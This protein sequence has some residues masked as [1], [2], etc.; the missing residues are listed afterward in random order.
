MPSQKDTYKQ[1]CKKAKDGD[2]PFASFYKTVGGGEGDRCLYPTRFDMY[3][4]GCGNDCVYCYARSL[5]GFRGLWNPEEPAMANRFQ[6]MQMIDSLPRNTVLRLGGMTDP[7]QKIEEREHRTEWLIGKLNERRIPYLIVTKCPIVK[8]CKYLDKELAHIQISVTYTDGMQPDGFEKAP[9][10]SERLK[11]CEELQERGFDV[12][13]RLSPYIPQIIDIDD[14]LNTK[15]DKVQVEFL[16]INTMIR[17]NMPYWDFKEWTVHE[18]G[19][20]H[21]P[22]DV[23]M[24]Y[25]KPLL[26]KKQVSVCEDCTVHYEFFKKNVNANPN[27]CCNLTFPKVL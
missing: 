9:A 19:Y 3:G 20:D 15:C 23:K 2:N 22:L 21:L 14:I 7:F 16:R 12:A 4:K 13:I 24:Q 11:A 27:D 26:G 6:I 1:F 25:L 8:D 18:G 17:R 10:P 5:L